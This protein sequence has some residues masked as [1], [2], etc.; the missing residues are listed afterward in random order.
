MNIFT[1]VYPHGVKE[2]RAWYLII[3]TTLSLSVFVSL[4]GSVLLHYEVGSTGPIQNYADATWT[5]LMS[6]TTIGFGDFY[7]VTFPGRCTIVASFIVGAVHFGIL[8][9]ILSDALGSDRSIQ[10]RELRTMLCEVMRK[11]EHQETHFNMYVPVSPDS[12]HLDVVFKQSPY[13]SNS[14]ERGYLT[15]GKDST[16]LYMMSVDAFDKSTGQEIHRW[17]TESSMSSLEASYERYLRN[18]NEL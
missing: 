15:I 3:I 4:F 18:A 16:G 11:L 7:G 9:S 10:N 17:S 13:E 6:M 1:K 8:I 12:H 5:I 2:Y 14:L